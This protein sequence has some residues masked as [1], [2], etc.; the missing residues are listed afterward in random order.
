MLLTA[1]FGKRGVPKLA[2]VLQ[3]GAASQPVIFYLSDVETCTK[4]PVSL[5]Q[6]AAGVEGRGPSDILSALRGT[7]CEL[8]TQQVTWRDSGQARIWQTYPFLD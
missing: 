8:C 1:V 7:V 5:G 6:A 3:L 4:S 2:Q